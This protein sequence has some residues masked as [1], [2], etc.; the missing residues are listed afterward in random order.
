MQE[1]VQR[2]LE[3]CEEYNIQLWVCHTPGAL[4]HRPDQ[5]SRGDPVEEPRLRLGAAAYA[6]LEQRWGPFTQWIGAERRHPQRSTAGGVDVDRLWVHPTHTTVGSALRLIGERLSEAGGRRVRGVIVVPHDERAGWWR[7]TRHFRVVGR[8]E[9][10]IRHL[11]ANVLGRWEA[12]TS[13]RAAVVLAFPRATAERRRRG[14][15]R[16]ISHWPCKRACRQRTRRRTCGRRRENQLTRQ[17]QR[18]DTSD[19]QAWPDGDRTGRHRGC[20][21]AGRRHS[22]ATTGARSVP[23]AGAHSREASGCEPQQA[24]LCTGERSASRRQRRGRPQSGGWP[25][26]PRGARPAPQRQRC[27]NERWMM[28]ELMRHGHG[29]RESLRSVGARTGAGCS[30]PGTRGTASWP[31]SDGYSWR[32]RGQSSCQQSC[33]QRASTPSKR[34]S[35]IG[36]RTRSCSQRSREQRGQSEGNEIEDEPRQ[37]QWGESADTRVCAG[38]RLMGVPSGPFVCVPRCNCYTLCRSERTS[39]KRRSLPHGTWAWACSRTL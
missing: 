16:E 18:A 21:R 38:G 13:Q 7:L 26:R 39:D 9:E 22:G 31:S 5:T 8:F 27:E 2:L 25:Q 34:A 29:W 11:E 17:Q 19:Q 32:C 36:A 1:L 4:L 24:V 6:E 33:E 20:W 37:W 10:G 30:C 23:A 35:R 3:A 12:A 15:K 28:R 14:P